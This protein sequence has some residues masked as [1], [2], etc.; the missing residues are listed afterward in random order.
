MTKFK[1]KALDSNGVT[2]K[3][4]AEAFTQNAAIALLGKRRLV[5]G[6]VKTYQTAV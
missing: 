1:Y 2:V 4:E 6:G 5:N 3:G